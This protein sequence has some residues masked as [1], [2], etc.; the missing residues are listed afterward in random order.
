MRLGTGGPLLLDGGRNPLRG[1]SRP[2]PLC[3][4]VVLGYGGGPGAHSAA[5]RTPAFDLRSIM[6]R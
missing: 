2:I 1:V 5:E 3:A 6:A 4:G